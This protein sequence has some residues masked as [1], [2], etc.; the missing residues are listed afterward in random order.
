M[1]MIKLEKV[2]KRFEHEWVIK[3]L[4]YTFEN[5]KAYAILGPNGS[6]KSTLMQLVSG[7]VTPSAGSISYTLNGKPTPVEEVF[8][9]VSFSGPYIQL[10]EEMTLLEHIQFHQQFKPFR[11][12]LQPNDIL[13]LTGLGQHADRQ[14]RNFSSGMKQRLKLALSIL[15]DT[16]IL[17]LDEPA[18]NL[19]EVGLNWYLNILS[20]HRTNRLVIVSSNRP[21]EY[22]FCEERLSILDYK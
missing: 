16:A 19:D 5:N 6:G 22:S 18:T 9:Q 15:S 20:Q 10:V 2:R 17:L 3:D 8:R 14:V 13:A 12:N 21:E 4:T 11:Q 7:A 1:E